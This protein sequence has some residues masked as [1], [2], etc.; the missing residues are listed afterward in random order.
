MSKKKKA[1]EYIMELQIGSN[2]CTEPIK[3]HPIKAGAWNVILTD[4]TDEEQLHRYDYV[5]FIFFNKL[6]I[7]EIYYFRFINGSGGGWVAR[8]SG[9]YLRM[10]E[11]DFE[12]FFGK[13]KI[14][15]FNA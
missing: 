3:V 7:W 10:T 8:R 15:G 6:Q 4:L 5:S 11:K 9:M 1:E 14:K 13:Y 2:G 12:K